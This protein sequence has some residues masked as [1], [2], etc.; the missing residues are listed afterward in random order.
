MRVALTTGSHGGFLFMSLAG[1]AVGLVIT[2]GFVLAAW[3]RRREALVAAAVTLLPYA[4]QFVF[5]YLISDDIDTTMRRLDLTSSAAWIAR[6]A[7][8]LWLANLAAISEPAPSWP[9]VA[10]GIRWMAGALWLRI[11][12]IVAFAFFGMVAH[13]QLATL[14]QPMIEAVLLVGFALGALAVC[15]D[16]HVPIFVIAAL[17]ILW[18]AGVA[19]VKEP[20][21]YEL[22]NGTTFGVFGG[23]SL[24]LAVP[25]AMIVAMATIALAIRGLPPLAAVAELTADHAIAFVVLELAS[26]GVRHAGVAFVAVVLD[27]AACTVLAMWLG[28]AA[29]LLAA[30]Q[31]PLPAAKLL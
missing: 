13:H 28:R 20:W 4:L 9:R 15:R 22:A 5:P 8:L 21:L 30:A 19:I 23:A 2:A 24:A 27:A 6:I 3:D 17:A 26:L 29:D 14:V 18:C 12:A 10:R 1:I 7:A 11:A 31:P 16:A 25:V